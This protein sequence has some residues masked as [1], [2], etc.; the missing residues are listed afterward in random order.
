M[1]FPSVLTALVLLRGITILLNLSSV[2][3]RPPP[4]DPNPSRLLDYFGRGFDRVR[5]DP[6]S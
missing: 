2:V 4:T 5:L 1:R 3:I 6:Y